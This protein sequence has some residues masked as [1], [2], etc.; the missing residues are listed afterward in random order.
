MNLTLK[1]LRYATT[2]GRLGSVAA[3][4]AEIKISQ[5][6]ITAAIDSLEAE[7]GVDLF[8]RL[9]AKGI[10]PTPSGR[11]ALKMME[12]ILNQVA[13]FESDLE[14]LG[15]SAC[16]SLRL[17]CY[18]TAAPYVLPPTLHAFRQRYPQ[19][20]ISLREGDLVVITDLLIAGEIDL[21]LTYR[22]ALPD[23]LE[24]HPLFKA[25]PYALIARED[26]LCQADSVSLRDLTKRP[27]VLLELPMMREYFNNLF[28]AVGV[29]PTI[30]HSSRSSEIIRALVAGGFGVS[31]LNICSGDEDA[32]GA[33]YRCLPI[34]GPVKV[35]EFGVAAV[36]GIRRP[37]MCQGFIEVCGSLRQK[38]AFEK[39]VVREAGVNKPKK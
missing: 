38:G 29:R 39:M 17:G 28:A 27:M 8:I 26:P 24:F 4:A 18:V 2:A 10:K 19:A 35:P 21:A 14:S 25:R 23:E 33:G 5:S 37:L 36:K 12:G 22:D 1:Q 16:G 13:Q 11:E 6:S 15:G 34:S 31:I 9:P 32:V 20:H 30:A 7:L 3:A